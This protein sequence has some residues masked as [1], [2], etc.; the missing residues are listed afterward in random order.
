MVDLSQ[1]RA[2]F[3]LMWDYD[4]HSGTGT[5]F[6]EPL[7]VSLPLAILPMLHAHL[8]VLWGLVQY[9]SFWPSSK[10]L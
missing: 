1:Y 2:Q 3:T 4:G 10:E 8:Q 9:N 7:V 5:V 6:S